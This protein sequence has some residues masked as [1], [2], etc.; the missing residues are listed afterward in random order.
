MAKEFVT[1]P[2]ND[3]DV[4]Q[5]IVSNSTDDKGLPVIRVRANVAVTIVNKLDPTDIQRLNIPVNQTVQEL[6]LNQ[7]VGVLRNAVLAY[8]RTQLHDVTNP[9]PNPA[10]PGRP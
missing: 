7:Q 1:T 5:V 3:V 8:A 9:N 2:V 6:N 4:D 10:T